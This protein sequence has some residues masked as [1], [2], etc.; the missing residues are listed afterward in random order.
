MERAIPR[1][2]T[3]TS[4]RRSRR[5]AWRSSCSARSSCRA[6]RQAKLLGVIIKKS[7][8]EIEKMER[9]GTILVAALAEIEANVAP[10][11]STAQL[12]RLAERFIHSRGG[13]P[14]VKGYRGFP[15]SICAPPNAMVVHCIPGPY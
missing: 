6:G 4:G 11:V 10:G 14:T 12:D 5:C 3:R 8:E 7:P 15:G 13:G 9:A 1:R 2:F